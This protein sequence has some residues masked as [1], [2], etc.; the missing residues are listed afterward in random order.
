MA[1]EKEKHGCIQET[2]IAVLE[3]EV[4]NRKTA[5]GDLKQANLDL[6]KEDKDLSIQMRKGFEK[7]NDKFDKLYLLLI[8]SL[9]GAVIALIVAITAL[10]K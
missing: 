6:R 4:D 7:I 5:N 2:R 3:K 1:P 9:G 8:S 10:L